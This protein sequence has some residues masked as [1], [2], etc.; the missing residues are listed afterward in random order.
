MLVSISTG[1]SGSRSLFVLSSHSARWS[2]ANN[3]NTVNTTSA[4]V[5][6]RTYNYKQLESF[7]RSFG[8]CHGQVASVSVDVILKTNT[9]ASSSLPVGLY[10]IRHHFTEWKQT[11]KIKASSCSKYIYIFFPYNTKNFHGDALVCKLETLFI[12]KRKL[13]TEKLT[14]RFLE[15]C[16]SGA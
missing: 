15:I 10:Y 13:N 14:D 9:R 12:W 6:L 3:T 11:E 7:T 16:I 1:L 2:F 5:A 4:I 8:R